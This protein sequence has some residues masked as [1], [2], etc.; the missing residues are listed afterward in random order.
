MSELAVRHLLAIVSR[1]SDMDCDLDL[2]NSGN[3]VD[4]FKPRCRFEEWVFD[5]ISK[6]GSTLI[7]GPVPAGFDSMDLQFLELQF[8]VELCL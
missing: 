8:E 2:V 7:F 4:C 3:V 6:L 1:A 5:K